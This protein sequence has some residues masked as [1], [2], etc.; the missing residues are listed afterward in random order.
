MALAPVKRPNG[1]Y[2]LTQPVSASGLI[3]IDILAYDRTDGTPY[4]NGLSCIEI[5][6]DGNEVF[7]YNMDNF[8]HEESRLI[9]LHMDYATE[10]LSGQR[11]HRCYVV[12]GNTLPI[13]TTD[14]RRGRLPLFDGQPH[15]VVITLFDS[16]Q[17]VTRLRFTI[18]PEAEPSPVQ[19][20]PSRLPTVL[21]ASASD[22]TL[23][24]KARNFATAE[25]PDA[26]FFSS[27]LSRDVAVSYVR[28]GE[29][30]Y[31]LDL[32]RRL[33]DSVQVGT[34]TLP[35]HYRKQI[36][37]GRADAYREQQVQIEFAEN[38]VY[39]TLH[40]AVSHE[41]NRLVINDFTIPLREQIRVTFAPTEPV[42]VRDR[43]QMYLVSGGRRDYI[44]GFWKDNTFQFHTRKLGTFQLLTDVN[45]PVARWIRKDAQGLV[46][47]I[48]DDLSGIASFRMQVNG[49]WVLMQYD[50]KR[51]LIWSDRLDRTK[52][53]EGPVQLEVKDRAGNVTLLTAT[54][55]VLTAKAD[56]VSIAK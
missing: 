7:A 11:F 32:S 35:L 17:N 36:I 2:V 6:L 4:K 14:K 47:T 38:S 16:Y 22:N 28:N 34:T 26:R 12:D 46:A 10:Q 53:F 13:Y 43:T 50:Y 5:E 24:I 25:V 29:A 52:P 15:E 40:L 21:T 44:G 1:E 55:P 56:S 30:V 39:D 8:P 3:G 19:V 42:E 49:E 54:L 23:L 45:P 18:Q 31:V 37:P 27:G 9:N 33:P 20:T 41:G 48:K 51:A